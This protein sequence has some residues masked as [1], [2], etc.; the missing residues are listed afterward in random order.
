MSGPCLSSGLLTPVVAGKELLIG[1]VDSL[2]RSG[3]WDG[4]FHR[5]TLP[6]LHASTAARL[7]LAKRPAALYPAVQRV[8]CERA[9]NNSS[10]VMWG[11]FGLALIQPEG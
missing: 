8:R 10:S 1:Y 4:R 9:F 7:H 5:C 11:F 3:A 2:E 6:P